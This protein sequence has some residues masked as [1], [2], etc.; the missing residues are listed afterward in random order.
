MNKTTPILLAFSLLGALAITEP[1]VAAKAQAKPNDFR[2]FVQ[3][4]WPEARRAGVSQAT[5]H[6]A[7]DDLTLDSKV[8]AL[9][10][11]Q[12]EFFDSIGSYVERRVSEARV[13]K[14]RELRR[15]YARVLEEIERKYG[16]DGD[17][18]L[19]VWGME[20]NFGSYTGEHEVIEALATLAYAG[21]RKDFF[22]K[23]FINAL[24]IA[25]EEGMNPDALKGSWAG[26]MGH[27]Q[28]MPSSY[29]AYAADYDGDG[30]RDIWTNIPDA[31]A[32]TANYLL[33]HGW[34]TGQ[35]W[36]YEVTLP[37]G[38]AGEAAMRL[39]T[40][41]TAEW[42][43]AGVERADG[44]RFPR[45]GSDNATLS[46]PAGVNGPAFLLLK[47]FDVIRTYNNSRSY[48]L[49]VGHLADRI[50]GSEP[51]ATTWPNVERITLKMVEDTQ[52][53][54]K[55][56]GYYDGEIDGRP[57]LGTEASIKAFQTDAG[58]V[59]DGQLTSKLVQ[60]LKSR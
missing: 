19:S 32:S 17:M 7:T 2:Q 13:N 58:L 5:F 51:F 35:T 42:T 47:N 31:L 21:K 44:S 24:I 38:K 29:R 45:S 53:N 22:R 50:G 4:L 26:A 57:G 55:R 1:A 56:L 20:T 15:Q 46:V 34:Q 36:G 16:V 60:A 10:R 23:E 9:S 12:P 54:L 18:V 11:K 3:S 52:K 33:K 59:P 40:R 41:T 6:R 27:T 48:A 28:F 49:A 30:K 43:N 37:E 8:L 25:E 39:G 14:G